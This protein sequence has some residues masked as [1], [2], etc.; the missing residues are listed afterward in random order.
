MELSREKEYVDQAIQGDKQAFNV[1][2]DFYYADCFRKAKSILDDETLAQDITQISLLQAYRSLD[3][4]QT[5]SRFKFWLFGIVRNISYNYIRQKRQSL[6]SL[7]D[8][9]PVQENIDKESS[10]LN[11]LI[12][13]AIQS[14]DKSYRDVILAYYYDGL[15]Q[16]EIAAQYQLTIST[17]KV[18]LHR[19][20]QQLKQKL[21]THKDL[22]YYYQKPIKKMT[23]RKMTIA[24]L[25]VRKGGDATLLLQT[26]DGEYFLPI[27]IGM[28]EADAIFLGL[29][30]FERGRPFTHDLT[31]AIITTAQITL[32][33]VCIYKIAN[34][35]FIADLTIKRGEEE[36][37]ID[38]RPSDA[39]ALA[40]RFNASILVTDEV[41]EKAGVPI[42]EAYHQTAPQAKGLNQFARYFAWDKIGQIVRESVPQKES[43]AEEKQTNEELDK[44]QKWLVDLVFGDGDLPKSDLNRQPHRHTTWTDALSNVDQVAW[45]SLNNQD[46]TDFAEKIKPFKQ[47]ETLELT[48]YQL[49]ELP[50]GIEQLTKLRQLNL[51]NNKLTSLPDTIVQLSQLKGLN[52]SSNTLRELPEVVGRLSA[53]QR[54]DLSKNPS[55]D[56]SQAFSVLSNAESLHHLELR[57]SNLTHLPEEITRL[58]SLTIL[59]LGHDPSLDLSQALPIISRL[60]SLNLLE[61]KALQIDALPEE[62]LSL[63]QLSGISL[64]DNPQLDIELICRQLSQLKNL[65]ILGLMCCDLSTLPQEI[66]LLN[67]L[68]VL[69]LGNNNIA[70]KEQQRIKE[71]LPNT[72]VIF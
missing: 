25:Y 34:G 37:K 45:L 1:L 30:D 35:V 7:D 21:A 26:E 15:A 57:E 56:L 51:A 42:P 66:R 40:V 36:L 29:E 49:T 24:D 48:G 64:N 65:R 41:L 58:P 28:L 62:I 69:N 32:V 43:K 16:A 63:Q 54:I 59:D 6:I 23:M 52:L 71:Q 19:A 72:T 60:P 68:E 47:I 8:L 61:I 10:K 22:F 14:L 13:S 39:I 55:L 17:V 31:A 70:R 2:A 11:E 53:L 4:L 20:R 9:L 3:K 50:S 44:R 12:I 38:A 46:L 67:K 18:R 5:P 27:I 33:N